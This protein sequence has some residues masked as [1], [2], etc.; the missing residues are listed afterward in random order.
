MMKRS[1]VGILALVATVGLAACDEE[2]TGPDAEL[3]QAEAS[4]VAQIIL[5]QTLE[6]GE[7]PAPE[8]D[9]ALA[10]AL[11][12]FSEDVSLTLP[13]ALGGSLD[14]ARSVSGSIDTETGVTSFAKTL[15]MGQNECGSEIEESDETLF[16]TSVDPLVSVHTLELDGQ[17]SFSASGD[18]QG[19]T[20][21]SL[22]E[23]SGT[24]EV[25]YTFEGSGNQETGA[26]SM[27]LIGSV[28]GVNISQEFSVTPGNGGGAV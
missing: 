16:L 27:A 19:A 6:G 5:E 14:V 23:R 9:P 13:C 26:L 3:S 28:C 17:G 11:I 24:C 25:D 1:K 15:E 20:S 8:A 10:E 22:G 4:Q 21:W 2:S 18:V 7:A 12:E